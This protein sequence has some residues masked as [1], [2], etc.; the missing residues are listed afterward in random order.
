MNIATLA[1]CHGTG[2]FLK[3]FESMK[4]VETAVRTGTNLLDETIQIPAH[5]QSV[6]PPNKHL[7][8]MSTPAIPVSVSLSPSLTS[9]QPSKFQMTF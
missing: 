1:S 4:K 3:N 7:R 9:S 6:P 5:C 2:Q 8:A